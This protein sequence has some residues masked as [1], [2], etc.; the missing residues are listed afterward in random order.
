M[1][2]VKIPQHERALLFDAFNLGK[3]VIWQE[4][5]LKKNQDVSTINLK[6]EQVLLQFENGLVF[7]GEIHQC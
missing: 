7:R 3:M 6:T 4:T 1:Y 5:F 2:L